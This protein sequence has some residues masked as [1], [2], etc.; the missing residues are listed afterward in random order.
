VTEDPVVQAVMRQMRDAVIDND[1][2]LVGALNRRI[3]L[4]ARLR[5]YRVGHGLPPAETGETQRALRYL[6]GATQGA[7]SPEA[8]ERVFLLIVAESDPAADRGQPQDRTP[9]HDAGVRAGEPTRSPAR[10]PP[11]TPSRGT[12]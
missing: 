10:N 12:L 4:V 5:R 11:E 3:D 6:R 2:A 1:V 9:A 7:L 8:L